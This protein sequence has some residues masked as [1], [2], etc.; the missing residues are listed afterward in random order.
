MA[1]P[2]PVQAQILIVE[3]TYIPPVVEALTIDAMTLQHLPTFNKVNLKLRFLQV[4]V[5]LRSSKITGDTS[6]FDHVISRLPSDVA[7]LI[8]NIIEI[9]PET[10]KYDTLRK[11]LMDLFGKS[12]E[13]KVR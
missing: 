1:T 2:S 8:Q 6:K 13:T 4:E 3:E 9:S 7:L 10:N 5:G 12:E 11:K